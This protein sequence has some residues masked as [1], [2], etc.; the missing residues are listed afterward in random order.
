MNN[1][2]D[3]KDGEIILFPTDTVYG[4]SVIIKNESNFLEN[5][6]KLYK[7]KK[8]DENKKIILLIDKIERIYNICDNNNID[9]KILNV[10]KN[11]WPGSLSI[12]FKTNEKFK[13][14]TK[15]D[16]IGV[17]IP[18]L[19]ITRDIISKFGGYLFVT[20]ANISGELSPKNYSD[21][22]LDIL[23]NVN[24]YIKY[25]DMKN[26]SGNPSTILDYSNNKLNILREG[27]ITLN[28]I[29]E[30]YENII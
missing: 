15:Y 25:E 11:F 30:I 19:S 3:A 6:S 14:I 4:L 28:K 2:D 17:R 27:E 24:Y 7:I 10:M 8:R 18:N 22:S 12:I 9:N 23:K 26:I 5:I 1:I 13:N 29:K 20:S 16:T 21:I